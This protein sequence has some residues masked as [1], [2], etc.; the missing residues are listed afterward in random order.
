MTSSTR[1]T[2][3]WLMRLLTERKNTLTVRWQVGWERRGDHFGSGDADQGV[4][5][6]GP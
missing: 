1:Q 4:L 3:W 5:T 2:A 6:G